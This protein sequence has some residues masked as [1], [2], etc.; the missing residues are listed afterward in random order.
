MAK[1]AVIEVLHHDL[2]EHPATLAWRQFAPRYRQPGQ[3][4]ILKNRGHSRV[5]RLEAAGPGGAAVVAKQCEPV[6]AAIERAIYAEIL[7]TLPVTS[8]RLYG[9]LSEGWL[10]EDGDRAND[11]PCW[12]FLE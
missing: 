5:Y 3:I 4:S 10:S 11:A 12:L 2:H 9:W 8:L 6:T 1:D 7:P